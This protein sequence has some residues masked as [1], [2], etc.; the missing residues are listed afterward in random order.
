MC[1]FS[2]IYI[3]TNTSQKVPCTSQPSTKKFSFVF[4]FIFSSSFSCLLS[5]VGGMEEQ[6]TYTHT[7]HKFCMAYKNILFNNYYQLRGELSSDPFL[8]GKRGLWSEVGC[9]R[10]NRSGT[11]KKRPVL[12]ETVA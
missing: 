9:D 1:T 3:D 6:H 2:K 8:H 11:F 5:Y 10:L 4:F 7:Y 12:Q